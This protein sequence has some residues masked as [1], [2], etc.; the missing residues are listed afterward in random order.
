MSKL[1]MQVK[2][3]SDFDEKSQAK[4]REKFTEEEITAA[5]EDLFDLCYNVGDITEEELFE[6]LECSK[7]YYESTPWF[8]GSA[9]Y[10]NKENKA[11]IDKS[12][13]EFLHSVVFNSAGDVVGSIENCIEQ[14]ERIWAITDIL[15]YF[16]LLT[17]LD[18]VRLTDII[19]DLS[20][21]KVDSLMDVSED[22]MEKIITKV[23]KFMDTLCDNQENV[24]KIIK[25]NDGN[26]HVE[27]KNVTQ[28]TSM[29]FIEIKE[30]SDERNDYR[31]S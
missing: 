21:G 19:S 3:F 18:A 26:F 20:L 6:I 17:V 1:M 10:A 2:R 16:E 24:K 25:D 27:I 9:F 5:V 28:D 7:E 13:T 29:D 11:G 14:D 8:V 31:V 4:F 15:G 23:D 22:W 30:I 12:V